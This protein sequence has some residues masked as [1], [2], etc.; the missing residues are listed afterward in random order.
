M[1]KTRCPLKHSSSGRGLRHRRTALS[2]RDTALPPI[3]T[4]AIQTSGAPQG[5]EELFAGWQKLQQL[6]SGAINV[7]DKNDE[8]RLSKQ[9][10]SLSCNCL[11]FDFMGTIPDDTSDEQGTARAPG[12]SS[13]RHGR[14][15]RRGPEGILLWCSPSCE[16]LTSTRSMVQHVQEGG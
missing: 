3:F 1:K 5:A 10:L 4:I 9:V 7:P 15:G 8:R 12:R 11:S 16:G 14:H 6:S 2:F 13:G